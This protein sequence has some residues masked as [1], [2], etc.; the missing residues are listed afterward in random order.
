MSEVKLFRLAPAEHDT[1]TEVVHV[2][3]AWQVEEYEADDD[4]GIAVAIFSGPAAEERAY[5]YAEQLR[6]RQ[7]RD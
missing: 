7:F 3:E 5:E 4:D 2:P 1:G 6:L